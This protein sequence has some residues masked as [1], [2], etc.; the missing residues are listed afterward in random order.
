MWYSIYEVSDW[1]S[2]QTQKVVSPFQR[3]EVMGR[4]EYIISHTYEIKSFAEPEG[5]YSAYDLAYVSNDSGVYFV[6]VKKRGYTSDYLL[7]K[8][9]YIPK[10]KYIRLK[11]MYEK[12]KEGA[13]VKVVLGVITKDGYVIDY[14]LTHRFKTGEGVYEVTYYA[15]KETV[16]IDSPIVEQHQLNITYIDGIDRVIPAKIV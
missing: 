2:N 14:N 8:G 11:G 6:E 3:Y 10:A 12:V 9:S 1:Y 7:S 5:E 13:R 15:R 16:N 4:Y